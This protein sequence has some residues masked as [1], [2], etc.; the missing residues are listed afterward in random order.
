LAQIA[1][2]SHRVGEVFESIR[3][4]F[5]QD[6]KTKEPLDANEVTRETLQSLRGELEDH[7]VTTHTEFAAGLPLVQG[8]KSQLQQVIVN[9]VHNSIEAMETLAGRNRLLRVKTDRHGSDAVIIV[10][11]DSGPGIEPTRLH[12]IFEA[13]V[14]T[15]KKGRHGYATNST[16]ATP[17]LLLNGT[18]VPIVIVGQLVCSGQPGN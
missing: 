6:E 13:F 7:G 5:Q 4:L 1:K 17:H 14:T 15:K 18:R 16:V 11:E 3:I 10:V 9:L 2:E 12:G 8:H